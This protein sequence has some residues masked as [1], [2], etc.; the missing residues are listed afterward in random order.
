VY[1]CRFYKI[2]V[3]NYNL[4]KILL[5]LLKIKNIIMKIKLSLI[6]AVSVFSY[7]FV[8]AQDNN[9][10]K[11]KEAFK[12]WTIGFNYGITK[13]NGDI[14]QYTFA[15]SKQ[16]ELKYQDSDFQER[17]SA[18][19]LSLEK[20]IDENVSISIENVSGEFAGLRRPNEYKGYEINVPYSNVSPAMP[21]YFDA[22]LSGDKFVNSFN[23][24]D[25]LL[26]YNLNSS[27]SK[28]IKKEMSDN[29]SIIL[30]VGIGYN[31]Y[32]SLRTD[33]YND[34]YIYS[35]GYDELTKNES[36]DPVS[37]SVIVGGTK[38][39]YEFDKGVSLVLDYTIRATNSDKWDSSIMEGGQG[40]D[41]YS[42]ISLGLA[43]NLDKINKTKEITKAKD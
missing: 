21:G 43:Y 17:R 37:E 30:K 32:R 29:I 36:D 19:F 18:F 28:L 16:T 14:S 41:R 11:M 13:F 20:K 25:I 10:I 23:E 9:K 5:S 33:L 42:I 7:S 22:K 15:S 3:S 40:Y 26:N 34:N 31:V 24:T 8:S 39:K 6:I 2:V 1:S 4:R 27:I 35:Y 38:L 12:N